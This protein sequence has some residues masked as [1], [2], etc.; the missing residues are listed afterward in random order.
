MNNKQLTVQQVIDL[1][2]TNADIILPLTNGEPHKLL[3]I[4][5]DHAHQLNNV[6]VHQL[7]AL[8]SREYMNGS[9]PG[10]LHHVSYF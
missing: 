2:P 4:L 10:Q 1:I 3:D 6:R 8:Q 5:E 7:L 9:F